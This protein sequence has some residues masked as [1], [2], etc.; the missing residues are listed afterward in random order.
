[1]NEGYIYIKSIPSYVI[2]K[3]A[4]FKTFW[5]IPLFKLGVIDDKSLGFKVV[6]NQ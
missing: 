4:S 6:F 1:M 5:Q 3:E 2:T